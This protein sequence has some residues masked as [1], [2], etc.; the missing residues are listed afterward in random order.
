MEPKTPADVDFG[1]VLSRIKV[2]PDAEAAKAQED[3]RA[4]RHAN[5]VANLQTHWGAPERHA[6][7][8]AIDKSGPWGEFLKK[9]NSSLGEGRMW[10]LCGT[11]G[12]GKT[13]MA[14]EIMRHATQIGMS[15]RYVVVTEFFAAIKAT[16]RKDWTET[17]M[18]VIERFRKPKLLVIDEIGKRGESDWE[19]N[20]LFLLLDKRYTD[21]TD[22]I[23]VANLDS[24][25]MGENLG[26]SIAS[27]LGETGGLIECTWPSRR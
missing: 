26:S 20:L 5:V 23:V 16:Y 13:Q 27:R 11:R 10:A 9:I 3:E 2:V 22:T 25:K 4:R 17:E 14:V 1:E 6:Q 24:D 12:N 15:A 19:N 7:R 18:N 21:M 8:T